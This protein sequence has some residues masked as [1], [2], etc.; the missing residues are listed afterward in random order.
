MSKSVAVGD[1]CPMDIGLNVLSGKWN[2]TILWIIYKNKVIRFNELQRKIG[3][4]T[5][6]AL[7]Q[8]LRELEDLKILKRTVFE[9]MPLHV[10]YSFTD[11]GKTLEPVLQAL[12]NWGKAYQQYIKSA[13]QRI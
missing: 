8:Q 6:K 4:I 1:T 10:E 13:D 7:T 11:I 3:N 12:C 5:T 9:E 2:L